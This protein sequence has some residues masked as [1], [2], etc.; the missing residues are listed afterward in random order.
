MANPESSSEQKDLPIGNPLAQIVE[1][2]IQQNGPIPF[3]QYMSAW[4]YGE[5]DL[6][7]RWVNGYYTG[8]HVGITTLDRKTNGVGAFLTPPEYSPL[9]GLT[10]AKQIAEMWHNLGEP[11]D[12]KIVEMGAGN[13]TLA[14]DILT[15]L[16]LLKEES[17]APAAYDNSSYLIIE[18]SRPLIET[19][20][21]SLAGFEGKV[22]IMQASAYDGVPLAGVTGVVVSTE[23]PDAFPVKM[24]KKEEDNWQ[25]LFI[26]NGD[27]D[28]FREVWKDLSPE[29]Q[30][31]IQKYSPQAEEGRPYPVNLPSEKWMGEIARFLQ[32]GYVI[33]VDYYCWADSPI[34]I[35][36]KNVSVAER[37]AEG[38]YLS[39]QHLG[40]SDITTGIDFQVL[41]DA[42]KEF[43][44]KTE[45]YVNQQGFLYGLGYDFELKKLDHASNAN[46]KLL[47]METDWKVLIQS[48][49]VKGIKNKVSGARFV[50]DFEEGGH[51]PFRNI[52]Y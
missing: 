50:Y 28:Y 32:K 38:N 24:V 33:T 34:R 1:Q 22:N 18:R 31:Y 12:F 43:G 14:R 9:Y 52:N 46:A 40:R 35:F 21:E 16:K 47:Y 17:D 8:E 29:A 51:R 13:G 20:R 49:G 10:F 3:D 42:G 26:D 5:A 45:G 6:N 36:G 19:Q 30:E 7:R 44:L 39:K 41:S 48:K 37:R 2:K 25:E 27:E 23:L 15:G 4:L 11:E